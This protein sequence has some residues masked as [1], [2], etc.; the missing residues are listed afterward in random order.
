M[1]SLLP[2]NQ[3]GDLKSLFEPISRLKTLL[4]QGWIGKIPKSE[5]ESIADHSY[6]VALLCLILTPCENYLRSQEG[7]DQ[8][9]QAKILELALLHDLGE[10][11]YLDID[12]N[13]KDLLNTNG[14]DVKDI[15]EKQAA[16]NLRK[17]WN[18]FYNKIISPETSFLSDDI[19]EKILEGVNLTSKEAQFVSMIDKIELNLQSQMYLKKGFINQTNAKE[20]LNSSFKDIDGWFSTHQSEFMIIPRLIS[21]KII[22]YLEDV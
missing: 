22:I 10:S 1:H 8:L 5:I 7:V 17:R 20:F 6:S 9:D 18:G 21:S 15:L 3:K 2:N 12:K 4:R 19:Y 11:Q 13:T 14:L 16:I